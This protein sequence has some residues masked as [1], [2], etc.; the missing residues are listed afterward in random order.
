MEVAPESSH[1]VFLEECC[2]Q[3]QSGVITKYYGESSF[4]FVMFS[5]VTEAACDILTPTD[6]FHIVESIKQK[7]PDQTTF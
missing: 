5:E 6:S 1:S 3:K 2:E 4:T 7:Q